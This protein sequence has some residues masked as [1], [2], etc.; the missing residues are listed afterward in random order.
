MNLD[1]VKKFALGLTPDTIDIAN[2]IVIRAD[3]V[4]KNVTIW[5]NDVHVAFMSEYVNF[6][7]KLKLMWKRPAPII[8]SVSVACVWVLTGKVV[9]R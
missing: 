2:E 7:E 4:T 3:K 6:D 5:L 1:K 9:K 8:A